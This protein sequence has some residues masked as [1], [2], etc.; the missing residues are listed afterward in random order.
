VEPGEEAF[1]MFRAP[2]M[3]EVL[4]K[5]HLDDLQ[6]SAQRCQQRSDS[7]VDSPRRLRRAVGHGLMSVGARLA[8]ADSAPTRPAVATAAHAR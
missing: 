6:T 2:E 3:T 8:G 5:A 1:A 4:V 7:Y